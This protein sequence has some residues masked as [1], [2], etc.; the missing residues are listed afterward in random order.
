MAAALVSALASATVL[1]QD[2]TAER[3]E[4]AKRRLEERQ[5]AAASR[6]VATSAPRPTTRPGATATTQPTGG[7]QPAAATASRKSSRVV[8]LID[9]SG[10]MISRMSSAKEETRK[11]MSELPPGT[12][13]NVV[14]DGDGGM[15]LMAFAGLV[16]ATPANVRKADEFVEDLSASGSDAA[17]AAFA[18]IVP[19]RPD[20]VW[21]A[22]DGDYT[23]PAKHLA[24]VADAA[25]KGR[26][27]V[28]TVTRFAAK[29]NDAAK[30]AAAGGGV[31]LDDQGNEVRPQADAPAAKPVA[32]APAP[33]KPSGPSIF[34]ER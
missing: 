18:A 5:R 20:V 29:P 8:F 7:N 33:A 24:K 34:R 11:A 26:F 9:G 10:S 15:Y 31:C 21:Y 14:V 30:V 6:P 32:A 17:S 27:R 16:P 3:L 22:T 13:F 23:E 19:L 25:R 1:A 12:L 4:A 2:V 28:N